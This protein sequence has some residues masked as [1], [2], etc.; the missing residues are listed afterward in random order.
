MKNLFSVEGRVVVMTGACGILGSTIVRHF[1]EEGAKVVMLDLERTRPL[2]EEIIGE[3][4]ASGG[5][6]TFSQ[7]T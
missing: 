1:A 2:A 6:I 5:E 3:V 4:K 7:Q